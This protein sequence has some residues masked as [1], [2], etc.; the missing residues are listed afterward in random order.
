MSCGA[1]VLK[2]NTPERT[3]FEANA[4]MPDDLKP[5]IQKVINVAIPPEQRLQAYQASQIDQFQLIN[6]ADIQAVMGDDALK[7]EVNADVGDFRCDYMFFDI[8]QAPFD[9]KKFRQAISHLVDRDAIVENITTP[10]AGKA[11]YGFLAPG[12]PGHNPELKSIQN[13]DPEKAKALFAESGVKVDKLLL[14]VRGNDGDTRVTIGQYVA[15]AIKEHLGIET[16]V[17]K[18]EQKIFMDKLNAKP[19]QMTFGMISY[20]MDYLDQS[21]MLSVFRTGGRHNWNNAEFQKLLDEA[22]PEVDVAKRND[23]YKK[24]EEILVEDCSAVFLAFR[25]VPKM[26]RPYMAGSSLKA[27]KLNTVPGMNWPDFGSLA[28]HLQ[29][30][31]VAKN[32][33]DFRKT[34]PA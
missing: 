21:N 25:T 6:T 10:I 3:V 29:E 32:V 27:G 23:L 5:Y 26:M 34:P 31:Y 9:N 33:A 2:E 1:F 19:T 28:N 30:M 14:E 13:Y 11:A 17:T 18:V 15:A 22:G 12:F 7:T 4:A 24:A 20:G 8:T 16:E